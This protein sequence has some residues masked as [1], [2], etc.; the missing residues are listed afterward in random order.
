L[1]VFTSRGAGIAGV[2]GFGGSGARPA[3]F[4][5]PVRA[6]AG[7]SA[8]DALEGTLIPRCRAR[9]ETNSL[10]TVLDAL[11]TSIPWS[12]FNSAITSW[13]VVLRSSATR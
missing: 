10:A 9:R 8:N 4:F 1:A 7:V 2:A 5:A 11:F 12:R 13:L 6:V 3:G